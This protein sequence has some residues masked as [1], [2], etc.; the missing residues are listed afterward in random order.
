LI[1]VPN[2]TQVSLSTKLFLMMMNFL[3]QLIH[4]LAAVSELDALL[5]LKYVHP[6]SLKCKKCARITTLLAITP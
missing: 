3:H 1:L 6:K 5:L 2:Q 4:R